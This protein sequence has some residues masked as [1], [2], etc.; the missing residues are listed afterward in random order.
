MLDTIQVV[1]LWNHLMQ[2]IDYMIY[3]IF[4]RTCQVTQRGQRR[5]RRFSIPVCFRMVKVKFKIKVRVRVKV[6]VRVRVKVRG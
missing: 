5:C 2:Q 6:K 4:L 3:H 1:R